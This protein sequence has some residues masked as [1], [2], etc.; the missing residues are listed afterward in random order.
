[1]YTIGEISKIVNLSANTLRYYD[2][3]GLLKPILVQNNNQYR[4]YS[5][6]QIK[7][8]IFI[9]EL[10]QF[11]FSLDEIKALMQNKSN[12]KLK[13]MLEEKRIELYQEIQRLKVNSSLLEKRICEII[14]EEDLKMKGGKILIVDDLELVR[15]MIRN[16]VEQYG[17]HSIGEASNGQEAIDA[18]EKLKPDL[19]IMD[20]VMPVMDG[21]EA[22]KKITKKYKEA[23]II[24][25]SAMSHPS[26]ILQSINAGAR[27]F[28]SKPFSNIT[29][30]NTIIRG[31]DDTRFFCPD[32]LNTVSILLTEQYNINKPFKQEDIDT[33]IYEILQKSGQFQFANDFIKKIS[34]SYTNVNEYSIS[35]SSDLREKAILKLKE[36]FTAISIELSSYLSKQFNQECLL[37][38][39]TV[40]SITIGEFK[41]L[42]DNDDST[43]VISYTTPYLPVYI[44]I[45]SEI[46]HEQNL[47]NEL[48]NFTKNIL[49]LALP[50]DIN[51][52]ILLYSED[53][54]LL[55][56]DY[57]TLLISFSIEFAQ[58]N[59]G[60]IAMSIPHCF[61]QKSNNL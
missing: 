9:M 52:D 42:I 13:Q 16:I 1:M 55:P 59:K 22:A 34:H 18:Y 10:K 43:G 21:I 11:G 27:D 47:L 5:D 14:R 38:L 57:S 17:Y 12:Q 28:I 15:I 6:V 44:H 24:M 26:I 40:E 25:C 4:Y 2:E 32:M 49:K 37:D 61:L 3:I 50:N 60:F 46:K 20:I 39:L 51:G 23:R 36:K 33:L 53:F 19:V 29:L 35:Q 8:I 58:K 56:D 48:L 30:M 31:S 41:T 7:D 54:K 45:S